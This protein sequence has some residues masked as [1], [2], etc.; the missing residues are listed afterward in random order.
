MIRKQNNQR[1]EMVSNVCG[2]KGEIKIHHLLEKDDFK[3]KC[4]LFGKVTMYPGNTI[5][6]H[7]HDD[8]EEIYYITKGRGR[9]IDDDITT[10]VGP[11]D[12]I[13]TGGGSKHALEN[14]GGS[15]LEFIAA[16]HYI[17]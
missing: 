15:E 14:I 5:G 1:S 11:G 4:N 2:G 13:V 9:V 17:K 8:D 12:A 6:L 7:V 3:G 16:I 10:E